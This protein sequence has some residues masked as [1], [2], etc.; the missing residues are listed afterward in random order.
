M[1]IFFYIFMWAISGSLYQ[2]HGEMLHLRML[3]AFH[4]Q[5]VV[6][7]QVSGAVLGRRDGEG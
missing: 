4:L 2:L 1:Y 3:A 7:Y 5:Q 6:N